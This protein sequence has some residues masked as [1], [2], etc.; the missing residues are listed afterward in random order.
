M[1]AVKLSSQQQQATAS[2]SPAAAAVVTADAGAELP[3]DSRTFGAHAPLCRDLCA[4]N[5][6]DTDLDDLWVLD[7]AAAVDEGPAS[8]PAMV[9]RDI[10]ADANRSD[11]TARWSHNISHASIGFVTYGRDRKR[12]PKAG[13]EA[14]AAAAATGLNQK[15]A[16]SHRTTSAGSGAQD[17]TCTTYLLDLSVGWC[18]F[19]Q[20]PQRQQVISSSSERSRQQGA[21]RSR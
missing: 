14:A 4:D 11:N 2:S 10:G 7:E 12:A 13:K 16:R 15:A 3:L 9:D 18:V 1:C 8:S 19:A 6:A 20:E 5:I 21:K 17:I